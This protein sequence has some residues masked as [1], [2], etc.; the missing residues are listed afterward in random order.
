[1]NGIQAQWSEDL[2]EFGIFP[3]TLENGSVHELGDAFSI[4]CHEPV[5]KLEFQ[6]LSYLRSDLV[7]RDYSRE[8]LLQDQYFRRVIKIIENGEALER[9]RFQDGI[10]RLKTG[11]LCIPRTFKTKV[12]AMVHDYPSSGHFGRER[13]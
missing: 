3:I 7:N 5:E 4:I 11:G 8:I 9:Y 10:L 12:L 13:T 1:M 2:S 6:N